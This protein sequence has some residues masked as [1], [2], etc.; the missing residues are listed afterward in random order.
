MFGAGFRL[1]GRL[2]AIVPIAMLAIGFYIPALRAPVEWPPSDA[3]WP[4]LFLSLGV[5]ALWLVAEVVTVASRFT[6]S[7]QLQVDGFL[8]ILI[9]LMITFLAGWQ[10]GE[11]EWYIVVPWIGAVIDAFLTAS[12]GVNN[13]AQ[14]PFAHHEQYS[15]PPA[16]R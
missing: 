2:R 5:M 14:K 11:I 4:A 16:P 8:S 10:R 6:T 13:A 1:I 3:L 9:A 15:Q 7:A 12:L